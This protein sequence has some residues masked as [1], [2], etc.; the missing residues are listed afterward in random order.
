MNKNRLEAFSDGVIA[1][2]I[3]IMVLEMK[4]PHG[5]ELKDL[6]P[7]IPVFLSYLQSFVFISN[8]W[9]NHHHLFHTVKK[10]NGSMLLAN[11]NLLFWLSMIP[12]AT[13]WVG[14]TAFA[15]VA[16]AIYGGL[17]VTCGLS[18]TLLQNSIEKN[19]EWNQ[20]IKDAIDKQRRKGLL[21]TAL[22]I[23]GILLAFVNPIISEVL[24]LSVSSMWLWPNKDIER[25]FSN[26]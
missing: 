14:E 4:M 6:L 26:E 21:S 20:E 8:Y 11:L 19:H 17:L 16:V 5:G 3:T 12:F 15:P 9:V 23:A 18:W 24:F 2:I 22:Y 10:V 1:I 7:L 13:G 25:A